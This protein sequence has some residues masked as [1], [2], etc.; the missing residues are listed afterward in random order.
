[1]GASVVC[2]T[3]FL[4]AM[5]SEAV[6]TGDCVQPPATQPGLVDEQSRNRQGNYHRHGV[7]IRICNHNV[8]WASP[9]L[10]TFLNVQAFFAHRYA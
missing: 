2:G 1:M 4:S 8:G 6:L 5:A 7:F 3:P 9:N 10:T